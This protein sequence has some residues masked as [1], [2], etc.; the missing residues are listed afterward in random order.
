MSFLNWSTCRHEVWVCFRM[1][2]LEEG[3][4]YKGGGGC[5]GVTQESLLQNTYLH[6][7]IRNNQDEDIS[8]I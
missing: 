3:F 7:N 8:A 5:V 2:E 1:V 4:P 6:N